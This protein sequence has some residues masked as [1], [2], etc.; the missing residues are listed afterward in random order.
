MKSTSLQSWFLS[1][2]NNSKGSEQRILSTIACFDPIRNSWT[3][4]GE[5]N[6]PRNT[7]GVIQ[8]DNEFIVVG[9]GVGGSDGGKTS[10]FLPT[11]S[12]I[13]NGQSMTCTTREPHLYRFESYPELMLISWPQS[14]TYNWQT[15]I[16][17]LV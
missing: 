4:L 15:N 3:K 10:K 7:H 8:I 5:L 1:T 14:M 11:E 2:P 17:K 12:C 16:Y 13:L 6:V 9:G